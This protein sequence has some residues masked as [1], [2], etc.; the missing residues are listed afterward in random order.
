MTKSR[1]ISFKHQLY[2]ISNVTKPSKIQN[3]NSSY[4]NT[5]PTEITLL[6]PDTTEERNRSFPTQDGPTA[7]W[8]PFPQPSPAEAS[9]SISPGPHPGC[10]CR[11]LTALHW[12]VLGFPFYGARPRTPGSSCWFPGCLGDP[13]GIHSPVGRCEAR[14]VTCNRGVTAARNLPQ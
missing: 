6:S 14:P 1:P 3:L 4:A 8:P 11:G 5:T 9:P 10:I 12:R 2:S 13:K 7:R